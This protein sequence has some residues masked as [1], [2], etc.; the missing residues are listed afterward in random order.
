MTVQTDIGACVSGDARG[1]AYILDKDRGTSGQA[2]VVRGCIDKKCSSRCMGD[3]LPHTKCT[4]YAQGQ[5]CQCTNSEVAG[6]QTC[7]PETLG[8]GGDIDCILGKSGCTCGEYS[9]TE[10]TLGCACTLYG[11]TVSSSACTAPSGKV[12]CIE[13]DDY[14]IKCSCRFSSCTAAIG[15]IPIDSCTRGD[16]LAWAGSV[17]TCSR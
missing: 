7:R 2:G 1:C 13:Q 9:C 6:T 11:G 3:R 16:V 5:Y 12:C 4:L 8:G 10:D 15:E 14:G 17:A